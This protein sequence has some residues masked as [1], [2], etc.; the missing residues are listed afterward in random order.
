MRWFRKKKKTG[1]EPMSTPR[2]T[3]N[4]WRRFFRVLAIIVALLVLLRLIGGW[5]V[6]RDLA[7]AVE[8]LRDSGQP[9]RLSDITPPEIPP[10][11]DAWP[12]YK[13]LLA[14][15]EL[16]GFTRTGADAEATKAHH[17][18]WKK[19]QE[20]LDDLPARAAGAG[21]IG[22]MVDARA[23]LLDLLTQAA[24]KPSVGW[25]LTEDPLRPLD[26]NLMPTWWLADLMAARAMIRLDAG[27]VDEAVADVGALAQL[28]G[29]LAQIPFH[30]ARYLEPQVSQRLRKVLEAMLERIDVTPAQLGRLRGRLMGEPPSRFLLDSVL[31]FRAIRQTVY[32]Q[33]VRYEINPDGQAGSPRNVGWTTCVKIWSL[34]PFIDASH[35]HSLR[36]LEEA[37]PLLEAPYAELAEP[38][39]ELRDRI[40]ADSEG[41]TGATHRPAHECAALTLWTA[42]SLAV[43]QATRR[44]AV[45]ALAA[46]AYQRDHDGQLPESLAQLRG[47]Y[48]EALPV[49]PM[50]GGAFGYL[51]AADPPR[52]YSAGLDQAD[53][54]GA[55]D[56]KEDPCGQDGHDMSFFLPRR[57]APATRPTTRPATRPAATRP[58]TA[59]AGSGD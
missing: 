46:G 27:Q 49:D 58:A 28:A 56:A 47:D 8:A 9:M 15:A 34:R 36:L 32:E 13:S 18:D 55:A 30:D 16:F 5:W 59:P 19:L 6:G 57:L 44:M 10:A 11:D 54:G 38:L 12:I 53:N 24:A 45:L 21:E 35:T 31:Y 41:F 50:T 4:K 14:K 20:W 23:D 1:E 2:E 17:A 37:I 43:A 51:P 29:H 26:A 52:V 7:P 48:I 40:A 33:L 39:T 22:L 3:K 42:Q 25:R